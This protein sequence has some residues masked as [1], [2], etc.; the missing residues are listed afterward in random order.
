MT[1]LLVCLSCTNN[2][3]CSLYIVNLPVCF[4]T[5]FYLSPFFLSVLHF[6]LSV[7]HLNVSS[8][9][10]YLFS[11]VCVDSEIGLQQNESRFFRPLTSMV[12]QYKCGQNSSALLWP[13]APWQMWD[14]QLLKK[15]YW[16]KYSKYVMLSF[17]IDEYI[18][19]YYCLEI[20]YSPNGKNT[21]EK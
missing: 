4:F 18:M 3:H 2:S 6:S 16:F 8:Q 14:Y 15:H 10:V 11:F 1:F 19:S 9:F 13:N 7:S 12:M 5:S 20:R 21:S 17:L